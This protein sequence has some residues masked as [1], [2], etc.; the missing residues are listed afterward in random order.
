MIVYG[1]SLSPYVRKVMVFAAE[2]GLP[3][4][5]KSAVPGSDD[6]DFRAISPFGKVPAFSDGDFSLCDSSAI[7]QYLEARHPAPA[8]IPSDP[9][10]CGKVIWFEEFADTILSQPVGKIF[11]NRIVAKM[12]GRP[13][14]PA[15][16]DEAQAHE[17][18]AILNWLETQIP[19]SNFLVGN[20][21]TLAD[22]AVGTMIVN[23]G[24]TGTAPDATRYPR[25][26]AYCES[27]LARPSFASL[28]A[29][30]S[31]VLAR[32]G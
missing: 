27:I 21:L 1:N 20:G 17:L 13:A 6:P 19:Q 26:A 32:A 29:G 28:I 12:L 30:E 25:L 24:H 9:Q 22:I 10:S 3:L 15:A 5:I 8:L 14:N 18:P 31:R 11:F 16:A 2:K 4:E 7:V 23:L